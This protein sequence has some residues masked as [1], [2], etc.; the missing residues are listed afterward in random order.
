[1]DGRIVDLPAYA[2]VSGT[3]LTASTTPTSILTAASKAVFPAGYFNN[4]LKTI[5]VRAQ[6]QVSNIVTTPGTLTLDLRMTDERS[7]LARMGPDVPH[8]RQRHCGDDH[9]SRHLDLGER[10]RLG[11]AGCW[12]R[13]NAHASE[14]VA[15]RRYGVQLDAAEHARS[16][17]YLEP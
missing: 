11:C 3:A 13:R 15:G 7:V 8:D 6:G 2:Q 12:W 16:L 10:H 17:R 1:M 14:R 4:A 9:A 5:T